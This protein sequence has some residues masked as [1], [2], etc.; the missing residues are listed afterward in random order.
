[1]PLK[2]DF[3]KHTLNFKFNAGTSRGVL[4]TRDAWFLKVW[5]EKTAQVYGIG[6][7]APLKGLSTDDRE[8]F[9][10]FWGQLISRINDSEYTRED[11]LEQIN[12][13]EFQAWPSVRFAIE[14]ALKDLDLGGKRKV[15]KGPFF[16]QNLPIEINGLV[17]MGDEKFMSSQIESKL[18]DGYKTIKM[19]IGAIDLDTEMKLLRGIRKSFTSNQLTLRVDANGAFNPDE[20]REVLRELARLEIHSIEQPIRAG[21]WEEMAR[22][23]KDAAVDIALDE[24]LIEIYKVQKKILLDLIKPQFLIF[25]PTLLGGFG[26]TDE[27]INLCQP[28]KINWWMTSALESNIGLNAICQYTD[29]KKVILPQGLGTGQL[30]HNNIPSP[31]RVSEGQIKY[32]PEGKWDL[33]LLNFPSEANSRLF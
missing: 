9:D 23:C 13:T 31:L 27:W 19:K 8:D 10:T 30:Y 2:A 5:D 11:L 25:K 26:Q 14:T 33:S 6:E 28:R 15:F 17:W 22:L 4:K 3:C 12:E 24:E 7:A 1:M 21:Q 18:S 29:S 32:S 20:A 16:D